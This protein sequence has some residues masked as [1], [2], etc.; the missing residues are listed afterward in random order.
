MTAFFFAG[1]NVLC[2]AW[3]FFRLPETK[4]RTYAELSVLFDDRVPAR[5]FATTAV[6]LNG[7]G[8]ALEKGD[9][10][11]PSPVGLH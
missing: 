6:H 1:A 10:F 11:E 9:S 3:C 5:K 7:R 4:D 2:I 8:E